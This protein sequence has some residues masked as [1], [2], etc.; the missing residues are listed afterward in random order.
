MGTKQLVVHEAFDTTTCRSGSKM[1]SLTPMTKVASAPS[2]GAETMTRCAPPSRW[3]A[4]ASRDVNRPVDSMTTS[5]PSSS[6]G[7]ALG[8]RSAST[9]IRASRPGGRSPSTSHLAVEG[10]VGGVVAQEMGVG[11]GVGEVVERHHL[12]VGPLSARRP[13]EVPP[14]P[15]EPVD[16]DPNRHVR[17]SPCTTPPWRPIRPDRPGRP[18]VCPGHGPDR[19]PWPSSAS[20]TGTDSFP[21][22]MDAVSATTTSMP[23]P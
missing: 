1:S 22:A 11:G 2:A 18:P 6:H 9:R 19:W 8:S 17:L 7:S 10:A 13:Q 4:A 20:T 21:S 14:D 3:P 16:P 12:E 5:T 23:T 15:P